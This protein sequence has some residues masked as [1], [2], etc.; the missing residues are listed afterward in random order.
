VK[1]KLDDLLINAKLL[2]PEQLAQAIELQK[3]S[4]LS[5]EKQ[6]ISDGVI[7]EDTA[8]STNKCNLMGEVYQ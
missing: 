1:L 5:L 7:T 3:K 8:N 4:G 6:L 2:T